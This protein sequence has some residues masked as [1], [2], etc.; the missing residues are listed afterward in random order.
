MISQSIRR[1]HIVPCSESQKYEFIRSVLDSQRVQGAT[2]SFYRYPARFSPSFAAA[3]IKLFSK[4]GDLVLDPYMGG[5]TSVVESLLAGR[6]IVGNDLNSLAVFI[7]QVKVSLLTDDEI[8]ELELWAKHLAEMLTYRT[9]R[10][11]LIRY[12]NEQKTKNLSITRGRFIKKAIAGALSSIETL[13]SDKTQQYAR[14]AILSTAQWALDG[15]RNHTTLSEFRWKLSS[16]VREM[17]SA[18]RDFARQLNN[19]ISSDQ[20]HY[21]LIEGNADR[22]DTHPVFANRDTR[23]KMVLT[24]PPYPGVHIL[25]HR[26][27][28]DGRRESPAPYWIANCNDGQGDS[29]YNFGGRHEVGLHGY[30]ASSLQTLLKIR[31]VMEDGAYIVQLV[32]FSD[33]AMQLDRYLENMKTAGFEEAFVIPPRNDGR[34]CRIW[35]QVPNRRWHAIIQ[36]ATRSAR[37]VVLIHRAA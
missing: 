2:H 25:Y 28:I 23:V 32:A 7:T 31:A 36:G 10:Q 26:W 33:P 35:R 37:E 8:T 24:S 20:L 19:P 11:M 30:F 5:G 29:F 21:T 27:Q 16:T 12:V 15:K 9:P 34:V 3:A 13:S 18:T 22:I 1:Y 6:R 17:L 14:C 4:P